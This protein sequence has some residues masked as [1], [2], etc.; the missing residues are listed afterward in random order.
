MTPT[1]P[2]ALRVLKKSMHFLSGGWGVCVLWL[3]IAQLQMNISRFG[4]PPAG[5]GVGTI[6]E[7]VFPAALLELAA[8]LLDRWMVT[9]PGVAD[10]RREWVHAFWWTLAPNLM[11]LGTVYLMISASNN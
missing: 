11:L 9:A 10:P 5:Y 7:G 6:F 1:R 2:S 8:L 4:V 3:W